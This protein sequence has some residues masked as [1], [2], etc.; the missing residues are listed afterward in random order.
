MRYLID[1]LEGE[2]RFKAGEIVRLKGRIDE[3]I[4]SIEKNKKAI[5]EMENDLKEIDIAVGM[6]KM[7]QDEEKKVG[8]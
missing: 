2:K 4:A 5:E 1:L 7:S 6:L 3:G 8:V